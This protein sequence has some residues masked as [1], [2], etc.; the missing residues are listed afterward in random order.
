MQAVVRWCLGNR[1]VVVLFSLILM[2]AGVLSIFRI[3]QELLPSVEFPSVF[4]LVTEPGA[5]PEQVDRD[6]T[7]PLIQNLTGLPNASHITTNSSQGFSQIEV[8]FA[9]DSSLKDDLDNLNRRL[10]QVQLPSNA[11][12]P[13]VQTFDF[14]AIPSMTYSLAATDGDLAR[15]TR[16]ANDVIVPALNGAQDAAQIR[17]SGGAQTAVAITLDSAKMTAHGVS[18]QQVQQALGSAQVDMPAGESLQADRTVPVEVLGSVKSVDDIKRLIVGPPAPQPG[19]SPQASQAAAGQPAD[20]SGQ[21]VRAPSAPVLLG[22]VATVSEGPAPV[23]GITRTDG[24]P[25]LSIQVIRTTSGNAVT[26]SNDIKSRVARLHLDRA[27]N[28]QLVTDAAREIRA[29]LNDLVLEG[30]L[31]AFL[32][33]LVIFLFLRSL[34]AT[35]VTAVSLPTSVLVALLGTNLWGFSLNALT[36]AGLTIAVGRIVDDAIVVLE[37]SYRH[38]QQGSAPIDAAYKGATE[39]ARPVIASTLTTVGVFLPIGVVGGIIS[40]FFLPFSVTVTISLL[41]SLLVALTL[42]PVLVSFLL[43]RRSRRLAAAY[44][45]QVPGGLARAYRPVLAWV[46]ARSWRK[47]GVL[48]TA[49]ALLIG[50]SATLAFVPKNFFDFGGST[51]VAGTVTLPAGTSAEQ[52][53]ERLKAFEAKAKADPAVK[54]TQ[55]TVASSDYGAYTAGFN[56]NEA[57]LAIEL[58]SKS[59]AKDVAKR[60]Q[61]DLDSL[62]GAGNSQISVETAGPPSSG[63]SATLSGRDPAA[64]RQASDMVVARLARDQE[65]AHVKSDLAAEKPELLVSVDPAKAAARGLTPQAVAFAVSGALSS[66]DVGALGPGGPHVMLQVDPRSVSA[67]KLPNLPMGPGTTLKDVATITNNLAPTSVTRVDGVQQ[68]TVSADITTSDTQGATSRATAD[69]NKLSLP[70]GVTL[71]SGAANSD[72]ANAFSQMLVAIGVAVAIVFLILVTFFRSVVTPFVILLTMPLALI[73]SFLALLIFHQALGLPALLGVLMVFGIVVSNAILLIDFVERNRADRPL[74]EAL[75]QAGSIRIRPIMMTAL[76]TIMA[77]VP[78]AAGI[79]T[80]GGGGLI[81]QPLALVVEGGLVSSTFLTLLVIPIVYSLLRR[82]SR[83]RSPLLAVD[84]DE[85]PDA[86]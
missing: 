75:L 10:S 29:S 47:V 54:I 50:A 57:R 76:A 1:A 77:L 11:G 40:R 25:S 2:G 13:I 26:L 64:L 5:G 18:V 55:V 33:V 17:V 80:A 65:L 45:A 16:E 36:L 51:Q 44:D 20:Q 78:I 49:L 23:N 21:S 68:V 32:A 27:D 61:A 41:A 22:D 46:L 38:L 48:G 39:V 12:K 35:L 14:S 60:L 3:N 24:V 59:G 43:Q 71:G 30:V 66:R 52:T 19:I 31:G 37:N 84:R 53:S 63:F 6:I 62:Y 9:L 83:R 72:L 28:F 56:T 85:A 4:V 34:R 42:I 79:S 8:S 15:A 73:G 86:A 82:R 81:G 7:Q 74:A 58:K 70:S 67:D 69:L